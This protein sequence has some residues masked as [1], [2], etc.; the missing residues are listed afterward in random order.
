MGLYNSFRSAA[1]EVPDNDLRRL[2]AYSNKGD[3][4]V[5]QMA[6]LKTS[7]CKTS[8]EKIENGALGLCGEAGECADLVKKYMFQGHALDRERLAEELGDVLWYCAELAAGLGMKLSEVAQM[9]IRK[10]EKRYPYGF[11]AD[12]SRN[13]GVDE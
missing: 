2:A 3:L 4:D 9:N 1:V 8:H 7:S 12:R 11:D 6:A 5:Y 10:L 13:R